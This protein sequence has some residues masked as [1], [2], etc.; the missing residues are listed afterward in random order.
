MI[1]H[2]FGAKW[3]VV[4]RRP[5]EAMA[6]TVALFAVLFVPIALGMKHLY[7]WVDPPADKLGREALKL[8]AHKRA[9]LNVDLLHRARGLLLPGLRRSSSSRLF[10]WSTKQDETG[11]VDLTRRQRLLGTG[12][13]PFIALVFTFAA[14]DWL[15][16][17]NPTLVLD[18]LRR[19][20]LRRAAS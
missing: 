13:L 6:T 11:E 17:L 20:L 5:L 15:M 1:F 19:L 16:S 4:L 12:A 14:F 9:Y 2:A 3:M 18:D 7:I 8:L 10:G